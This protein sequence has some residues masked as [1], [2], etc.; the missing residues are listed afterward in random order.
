MVKHSCVYMGRVRAFIQVLRPLNSV[1]VG[2]SVI[3][4][5]IITGDLSDLNEISTT[6]YSFLT[7][8]TLSGA[9]MAINDYFDIETDS[10]NEPDRP[11]PR[12]DLRPI[13]AIILSIGFSSLGLFTSWKNCQMCFGIALLA[14]VLMVGYS[15]GGKKTGLPGNF[16]VS[17]CIALPFIYGGVITGKLGMALIFSALAF[18]SNNGREIVKGIVDI[19]GD[20]SMGIN[21]VAVTRGAAFA[22]K[23]ATM[24]YFSSIVVS[25]VPYFL[26]LVSTWYIPFVILTDIILLYGICIIVRSPTR[27]NSRKNKT[28]VLYGMVLGLL[29][30]A[31]GNLL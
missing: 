9:A 26:G 15:C 22:A 1:M 4:G 29:G 27:E 14:L 7:G 19:E 28:I 12:G 3:V 23:L 13:E 8:F 18:L 6:L 30:F 21:T 24:F 5:I 2:I 10:I 17:T 16:M 31:L 20:I 25:F 11:I